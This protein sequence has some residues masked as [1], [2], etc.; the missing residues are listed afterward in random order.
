MPNRLPPL[1]LTG[2]TRERRMGFARV[3]A[4]VK[5]FGAVCGTP[6]VAWVSCIAIGVVDLG[7]NSAAGILGA[8]SIL[9]FALRPTF[10]G[11]YDFVKN[12]LATRRKLRCARES[13]YDL[14][15]VEAQK[16]SLCLSSG[17]SARSLAYW[18]E[19]R[20]GV[21]NVVIDEDNGRVK[22]HILPRIYVGIMEV[23]VDPHLIPLLQK[24]R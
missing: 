5:S 21:C 10:R 9:I 19:G 20:C 18:R 6:L 15:L 1:I 13:G 3:R 14:P 16:Y 24:D 12:L 22:D 11:A 17:K 7:I 8:P 2:L 23:D 4:I